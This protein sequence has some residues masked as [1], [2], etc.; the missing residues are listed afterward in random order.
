MKHDRPMLEVLSWIASIAAAVLAFYLWVTPLTP[1]SASP[2]SAQQPAELLKKVAPSFD[3]AKARYRSE[4]LVCSSHE[5]SVLDLAMA[6][7]Y[8]DAVARVPDRKTDLRIEQNDWLR[9]VRERCDDLSC[10]KQV[11]EHR[12]SNLMSQLH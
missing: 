6:N 9:N 1:S 5:L 10:L 12:I 4:L 2:A 7:S 11:Y 8:R 3:C